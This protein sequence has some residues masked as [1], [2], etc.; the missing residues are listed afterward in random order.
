MGETYPAGISYPELNENPNV[1]RDIQELA[2]DVNRELYRPFPCLSTSR[3]TTN[4]VGFTIREGDTGNIYLWDGSGWVFLLNSSGGSSGGGAGGAAG[5]WHGN[6]TQAIG[7]TNTV[8]AASTEDAAASGIT[9][10]TQGSG[11]KW[12]L[13]ESGIYA[14]TACLYFNA[15]GGGGRRLFQL[16]NP[17]IT[18]HHTGA[19]VYSPSL[20]ECE[21]NISKTKRFAAGSEIM[22]AANQSGQTTLGALLM[23]VDIAKVAA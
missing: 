18:I 21:L 16:V 12:T 13:T 10:S 5:A 19:I 6:A 23:N 7:T 17:G 8:I 20:L 22:F 4:R 1:P 3:P 9:R 15:G 2:E 14:I 11:H